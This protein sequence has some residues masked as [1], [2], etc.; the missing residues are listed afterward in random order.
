MSNRKNIFLWALYDFANSIV[1]IAFLFYFSQWLVIDMRWSDAWYNATL[2][3]GSIAF[4]IVGPVL[5]SICDKTGDRM[6]GLRVSTIITIVLFLA[7]SISALLS[8]PLAAVIFYSL[9]LAAYLISFVFYTPLMNDLV[10]SKDYGNISGWGQGANVA[11]QIA[12]LLLM[13]PI[14]TGKFAFLG[15]AGGRVQAFIPATLIFALLALP[16]LI[17]FKEKRSETPK[18]YSVKDEYKNFWSTLVRICK[19]P[20]V[21]LFIGGYLFFSDALLTFSNNYPIWLEKVF[22]VSD[23][24]KS[25]LTAL[26]LGLSVIGSVVFGKLSDKFGYKKILLIL[27]VSWIFLFPILGF[28]PTFT[29]VLYIS[30][31]AGLFF[32]GV[33]SVSRAMIA[34]MA[35]R[36]SMN[37]VFS[38]YI[39]AERFATFIGPLGWSLVLFLLRDSDIM[40]YRVAVAFMSVFVLIGLLFM[41]RIKAGE[42]RS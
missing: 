5:G 21:G 18:I 33:W 31:I 8:S 7:T 2:V 35:P 16:M 15:L 39:F 19:M 25:L 40:K 14:V 34:H 3:I 26:I 27:L 4:L 38:Y 41:N 37:T 1:M 6:K 36:D 30:I 22:L 32:G 29:F 17:W 23:T 11:G 9:A 10:T 12:G 24:T 28:A 13:I 42:I 20:N